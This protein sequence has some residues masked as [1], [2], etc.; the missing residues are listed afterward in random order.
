MRLYYIDSELIICK[1]QPKYA[2]GGIDQLSTTRRS[3]DRALLQTFPSEETVWNWT[4]NAE[5]LISAAQG[6]VV[7][8]Y[9]VNNPRAA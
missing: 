1:Y 3:T 9:P 8:P 7:E 5:Y 2:Y 4:T 6:R